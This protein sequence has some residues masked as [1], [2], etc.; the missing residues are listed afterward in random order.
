[1]KKIM[2]LI[3]LIAAASCITVILSA[4]ELGTTISKVEEY[5]QATEEP[6]NKVEEVMPTAEPRG[7]ADSGSD[8][9]PADEFSSS[10]AQDRLIAYLDPDSGKIAEYFSAISLN[11]DDYT[12]AVRYFVFDVKSGSKSLGKYYV[13]DNKTDTV[14]YD[15]AGFREK[16]IDG[17]K[18]VYT[19]SKAEKDLLGFLENKAGVTADY[20]T[21]VTVDD[22]AF[23][24]EV[25]YYCFSVK[26]AGVHLENYY[27]LVSRFGGLI[28]DETEFNERTE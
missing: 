24:G 15:G 7:Q 11:D 27:V 8:A 6:Q 16:Y 4:C 10:D 18:D 25:Q 2:S 3:S 21:T 28:E 1:M 23:S 20:H 12:Y 13:L 17:A 19:V 9:I 22:E 5:L 26:H 14:I